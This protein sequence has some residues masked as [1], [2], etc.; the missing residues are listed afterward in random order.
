MDSEQ[1]IIVVLLA[2]REEPRL[3]PFFRTLLFF[4]KHVSDWCMF[5]VY[6]CRKHWWAS[7]DLLFDGYSLPDHRI[8]FG[9][10]DQRLAWIVAV[11]SHIDRGGAELEREL[12]DVDGVYAGSEESRAGGNTDSESVRR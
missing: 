5:D 7:V 1:L 9:V 10:S 12:R 2:E 4:R 11:L 6:S 8:H 3:L